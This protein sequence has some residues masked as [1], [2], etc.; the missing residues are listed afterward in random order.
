VSEPSATELGNWRELDPDARRDWWEQLW[1]SAIALSGRYRLALRSGW[2]ENQLQT[3]AL[4]AFAAWVELYD[5]STY[6]DPPGKLQLLWEL[7][8]LKPLLRG[9]P[10]AFDP[11]RDRPAFDRYLSK[12]NPNE[13]LEPGAPP[14]APPAAFRAA[15]LAAVTTRRTELE[16]RQRTLQQ[17]TRD[18]RPQPAHLATELAE[19]QRALAHLQ[20]EQT[21][22]HRALDEQP[23]A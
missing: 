11:T 17:L 18:H 20:T 21:E 7:D 6:T 5:T 19:L 8:R 16:Q 1:I 4:V 15:E 14:L 13:P 2:W 3:E 23:D 22:L 9:G 10:A 12:P